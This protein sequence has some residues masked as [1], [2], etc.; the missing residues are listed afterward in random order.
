[1]GEIRNILSSIKRN[2]I[3]ERRRKGDI[4]A[5]LRKLSQSHRKGSL[6]YSEDFRPLGGQ[7]FFRQN[8]GN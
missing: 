2:A 1:M 5:A 4:R 8:A 3:T 6:I 7:G